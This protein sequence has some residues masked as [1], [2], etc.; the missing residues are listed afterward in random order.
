[1]KRTLCAALIAIFA[2]VAT[3]AADAQKHSEAGLPSVFNDVTS[4]STALDRSAKKLYRDKFRIIETTQ[5]DGLTPAR[6]KGHDLSLYGP[7]F[8]DP[9]GSKEREQGFKVTCL[10]VIT[11]DGA[12]VEPRVIE[13]SD[14]RV[15]QAIIDWVRLRR[16]TAARYRGVPVAT[17]YAREDAEGPLGHAEAAPQ[18]GLGIMGY[19]DR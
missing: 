14:P 13:A 9:R 3:P 7:R 16:W 4:G 8:R 19:R 2:T 17:L 1:M 12:A 10:F 6:I 15:A 11:A 18:N 5:K